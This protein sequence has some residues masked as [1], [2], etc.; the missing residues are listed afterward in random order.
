MLFIF[1]RNMISTRNISQLRAIIDKNHICSKVCAYCFSVPFW[2]NYNTYIAVCQDSENILYFA[3]GFSY[4]CQVSVYSGW[5]ELCGFAD[6]FFRSVLS[7]KKIRA[8]FDISIDIKFVE[9]LS[10]IYICA[11]VIGNAK[12]L[13]SQN[14]FDAF[15]QNILLQSGET[16]KVLQTLDKGAPIWYTD[17]QPGRKPVCGL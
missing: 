6:E 17:K 5:R 9:I 16:G 12:S 2:N 14:R 15:V 7:F 10:P 11:F 4:G 8:I 13:P 3:G 1:R